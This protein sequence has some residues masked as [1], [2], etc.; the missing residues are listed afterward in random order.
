MVS[1]PPVPGLD[2]SSTGEDR[3]G[4][5]SHSTFGVTTSCIPGGWRYHRVLGYFELFE[6]RW[7][8]AV[9]GF[10]GETKDLKLWILQGASVEKPIQDK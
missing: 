8:L 6:V 4:S 1:S 10:G 2:A 3:E 7:C 5:G 9:K